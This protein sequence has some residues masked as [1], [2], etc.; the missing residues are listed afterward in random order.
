MSAV[1]TLGM[2]FE[3]PAK[4]LSLSV[5]FGPLIFREEKTEDFEVLL[6]NRRELLRLLEQRRPIAAKI[7]INIHLIHLFKLHGLEA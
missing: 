5:Q 6:L 1:G 3:L 7:I 2:V 4:I